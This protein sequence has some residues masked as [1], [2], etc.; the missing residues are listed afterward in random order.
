MYYDRIMREFQERR[1]W[2]KII[3][4]R[5]VLLFLSAVLFFTAYSTIKIYLKSR[6]S[7]SVNEMI[8]KEAEEMTAKKKDLSA[9]ISRLES[10]AGEEEEIRKRFPVQKPG[11]KSV[12][13]IEEETKADLYAQSEK[14][15]FQKIWQFVKDIF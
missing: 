5:I 8:Q 1:I 2:R 6:E 15:F 12:I 3:F 14:S 10:P 13:I 9:A 11:E 4:S 7:V